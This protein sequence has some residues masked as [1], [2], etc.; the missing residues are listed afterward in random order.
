M[1]E[2]A[3]Q[4][5]AGHAA[6][7]GRK[8]KI[9]HIITRLLRAGSEENTVSTCVGHARLGHDVWLFHGDNF[10]SRH[11]GQIGSEVH[12]ECIPEMVH[13]ISPVKDLHAI[14]RMAQR[15]KEIAPDI[16]HTHQSKAGI[17][18]RLAARRAKVP[19][20][21]HGVHIAPFVNVSP[22]KSYVYELAER[23]VTRH[24]DA[25]I[26]VS[27]G[28]RQEYLNRGIGD[29]GSFHVVHSGMRLEQFTDAE[30]PSD[31]RELIGV[32]DKQERPPIVLM[33]AAF[34]PRK[35]HCELIAAFQEVVNRFPEAR[36]LFAGEG[37]VREKAEAVVRAVSLEK[38][39]RFVGF[40]TSP[41]KLVALADI[42]VLTSKREGLPRVVIQ[43]L[44]G[45]KPVVVTHV[46]GIEEI[47]S[48]GESGVI[49]CTDSFAEVS[50][51]L[52][53][54]LSDSDLY[55]RLQSGAKATDLSSWSESS[56]VNR[57]ADVYF[58]AFSTQ[59]ANEERL[60]SREKEV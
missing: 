33:L 24:T 43:Y 34:E 37:T 7:D 16:V 2:S 60:P 4:Q 58:E 51:A 8:L 18:G 14:R 20:I 28:M 32:G 40:H 39:V 5:I 6:R 36:L 1:R 19:C 57:T 48:D 45:G 56:L 35:R 11:Y 22:L 55:S 17:V 41:G 46:P 10:D 15:L 23:L 13:P 21:I 42:C 12:L 53:R 9:V 54:L 3:L 59:S 30:W 52:V 47:V 38:N 26:A 27:E 50:E 49:C 44:A 25:F 29:P 31:W